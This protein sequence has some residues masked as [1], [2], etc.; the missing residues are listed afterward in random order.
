MRVRSNSSL[1]AAAQCSEQQTLSA[2]LAISAGLAKNDFQLKGG[3]EDAT[4]EVRVAAGAHDS[5]CLLRPRPGNQ[6]THSSVDI[7]Q[8]LGLYLY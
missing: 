2:G 4:A 5:A 3:A 8:V 6:S 1:V 7:D